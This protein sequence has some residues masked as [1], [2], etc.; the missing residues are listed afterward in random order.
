[1]QHPKCWPIF[2][3]PY[4]EYYDYSCD[5]ENKKVTCG[6]DNDECEMFI[7]ECDRKAVECFARSTWNPEHEHLPIH[8]QCYSDAMQHTECWPIVDNPYTELYHYSCDE[9]NKKVTC[10]NDNDECEMFICECDRKAVECFARSTWNP[11]HE[12]LPS[13]RCE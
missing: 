4:T 3:N 11:E 12:H 8:D 6:N 1:M 10:D 9:Q 5:K 13:D 7:C 2:D